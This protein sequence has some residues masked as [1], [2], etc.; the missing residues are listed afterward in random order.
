MPYSL[1]NWIPRKNFPFLE[2]CNYSDTFKRSYYLQN[3][4]SYRSMSVDQCSSSAPLSS[5]YEWKNI[6]LECIFSITSILLLFTFTFC[7]IASYLW[8][9]SFSLGAI[10]IFQTHRWNNS[11]I[12]H[13]LHYC[14][15]LILWK[16]LQFFTQIYQNFWTFIISFSHYLDVNECSANPCGENAVCTDTVGSFVCSCRQDYTGDP[17]RKCVGEYFSA[18]SSFFSSNGQNCLLFCRVTNS[19]LCVFLWTLYY[20][21]KLFEIPLIKFGAK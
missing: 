6:L 3:H 13:H 4:P 16:A 2:A 17:Y 5:F 18:L 15:G 10:T 9:N 11:C 21:R 8:N 14:R 1:R 19:N 12:I 20:E 7:I